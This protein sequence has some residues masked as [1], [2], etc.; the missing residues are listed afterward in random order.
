MT[1]LKGL[2]AL[3]GVS[4]MNRK[5]PVPTSADEIRELTRALNEATKDAR[6]ERQATERLLARMK[7]DFETDL[8][9]LIESEGREVRE[10]I[11]KEVA[12]IQGMFEETNRRVR[13]HQAEL[14]G[15]KSPEELMQG[16]LDGIADILAKKIDKSNAEM[17]GKLDANLAKLRRQRP[18]AP[19]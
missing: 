13:G 5:S 4:A 10:L 14:L 1:F 11:D 8:V 3:A 7:A 2:A 19:K 16:L 9:K 17:Y 6:Q 18:V 12:H 15:Y